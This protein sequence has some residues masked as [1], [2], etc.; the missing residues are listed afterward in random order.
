MK[1][2][3]FSSERLSESSFYITVLRW[4]NSYWVVGVGLTLAY[5]VEDMRDA[6]DGG[7]EL[8]FIYFVLMSC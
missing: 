8:V 1:G 5:I 4:L 2:L 6:F 3:T 7:D